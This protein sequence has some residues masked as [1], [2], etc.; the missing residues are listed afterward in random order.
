MLESIRQDLIREA[1]LS[2]QFGINDLLDPDC[3]PLKYQ[4]ENNVHKIT[5]AHIDSP[6]SP[7]PVLPR[8]NVTEEGSMNNVQVSTPLVS[9][10]TTSILTLRHK[11]Q[12]LRLLIN[13]N[14]NYHQTKRQIRREII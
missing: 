8:S 5:D 2:E 10:G 14:A 3:V 11:E 6:L 1:V 7:P 4:S 13:V 12:L 9:P